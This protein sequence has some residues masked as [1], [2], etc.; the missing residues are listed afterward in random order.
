MLKSETL[1]VLTLLVVQCGSQIPL[2]PQ[3]RMRRGVAA[4]VAASASAKSSHRSSMQF[5]SGPT[6]S[7]IDSFE[8]P[9]SAFDDPQSWSEMFM[10]EEKLV[11]QLLH[12][13][14]L[15]VRPNGHNNQSNNPVHVNITYNVVQIL[16]FSQ[17][18][19]TLSISGWFTI[20]S[21]YLTCFC[22]GRT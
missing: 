21:I 1:V 3:S 15:V 2:V 10:P 17:A 7:Y 13:R 4:N 9:Q 19:E 11:A 16:A 8:D 12:R 6:K 18:E 5:S 14:S 22:L 20:V